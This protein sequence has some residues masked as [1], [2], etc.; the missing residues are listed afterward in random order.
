[1]RFPDPPAPYSSL[2]GGVQSIERSGRVLF[3]F[4]HPDW[5]RIWPRVSRLY[6]YENQLVARY[7]PRSKRPTRLK[8][9]IVDLICRPLRG[10]AFLLQWAKKK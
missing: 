9:L 3:D 7:L 1:M 5:Q 8:K 6:G 4:T 2:V 10:W